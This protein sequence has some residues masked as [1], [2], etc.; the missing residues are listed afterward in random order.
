MTVDKGKANLYVI[1]LNLNWHTE[2]VISIELF[3]IIF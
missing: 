1:L 2:I 3:A